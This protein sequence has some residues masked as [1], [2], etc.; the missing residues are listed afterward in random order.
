MVINIGD[1]EKVGITHAILVAMG[2]INRSLASAFDNCHPDRYNEEWYKWVEDE[3]GAMKELKQLL[4]RLEEPER[5]S[6]S[7]G[8]TDER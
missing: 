5:G 3:I 8:A 1:I 2:K 7:K 6:L 4:D